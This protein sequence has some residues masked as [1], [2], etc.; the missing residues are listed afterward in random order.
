[1]K[2]WKRGDRRRAVAVVV[3]VG[4]WWC[5]GW[6]RGI[7]VDLLVAV[8]GV[9]F[10]VVRGAIAVRGVGISLDCARRVVV[11]GERVEGRGEKKGGSGLSGGD[12]RALW[13]CSISGGVKK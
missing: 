2:K 13:R 9:R 4:G 12:G 5:S 7:V 6:V 3:L 11:G 1:M 10:S 8:G